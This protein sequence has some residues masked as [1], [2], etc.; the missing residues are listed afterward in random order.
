LSG[1]FAGALAV[2]Q[3]FADVLAAACPPRNLTVSLWEPWTEATA[4]GPDC[5]R[6]PNAL[7]LVG[8]GHLGQAFVWTLLMLP[9]RGTRRVVLQDDQQIDDENEATSLLV[10]PGCEVGN[11]KVRLAN[12]WL[13]FGGWDTEM[14]ERQHRGDLRPTPED[15]PFLLAGLDRLPPRKMLAGSGFDYMIDAGI[16]HGS[17]DFE[18]IQIRVIAKGAEIDG[19]WNAPSATPPADRLL[20]GEAYRSLER[21]I[22]ACGTFSLANASVAVPFVGAAAGA[23]AIAQVIRLASMQPGSALLQMELGS[24]EMVIDGGRSPAPQAFL[25]G[26]TMSLDAL[27]AQVEAIR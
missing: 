14:I 17:G 19:L 22:G 10:L 24:P 27:S 5:F 6:A 23:L 12:R 13:E 4:P 20:S 26:E 7:W 18:G 2:R 15:P 25:G 1:S 21:E 11:R 16:G 8:L 3:V 9:Y